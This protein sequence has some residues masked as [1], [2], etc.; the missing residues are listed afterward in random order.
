MYADVDWA[1]TPRPQYRADGRKL[2]DIHSYP[3]PLRDELQDR[4]GP[5]PLFR[6][7][8]PGADIV[9]SQWIA[10]AAKHIMVTRQPT[11]TLVYLPHLDYNL[12]RLGPNDPRIEKDVAAIDAVCGQ[13]IDVA[14]SQG[15]RIVVLSEYG[16][17][18]V[19]DAVH[20]NRALRE[21]GWLAIRE[22]GGR[23]LLDA[24]ASR[25]FAVADH[26]VAH[27]YV[28][29][30]A[31]VRE[32]EAKVASLEGVER[33]WS[34]DAK[35]AVGLD[36]PRSGEVVA[37]SESDRWFSYYYWLDDAR[38]PD[39]AR[40]VDI[41][42]KPG[43]DPV[44]LFFDPELR[45]PKLQIARRLAKKKL[46]FRTLMDVIPL[47]ADLVRGAHGR[48]TDDP[49][50][51]PLLMTNAPDCLTHPGLSESH[52]V[53]GAPFT[54]TVAAEDVKDVLLNHVFGP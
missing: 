7:W 2:P 34:G 32:V 19:K 17:T 43:Y 23:E 10:D 30:P 21:A 15:A 53:T 35:A 1:V 54:Q 4:L 3:A 27:V 14:S 40:T 38:A 45:F 50:N 51:G 48:P 31:D 24:G 52:N 39:F 5:F 20:I 44:E 18:P 16:I 25:A 28:K 33:T 26:Q 11:M 22:E 42:K 36:H 47:K 46:G 41:H 29:E 8:G 9:C 6:F 37:M 49:K 13:L 12:Q